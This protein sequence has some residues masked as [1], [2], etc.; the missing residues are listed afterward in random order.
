M[1]GR[2]P[3]RYVVHMGEL[4]LYAIG[5][6]EV[7]DVF[8]ASP[9]VAQDF[10]RIVAE[11]FPPHT[12]TKAPGMLGKLGPLLRRPPDAVILQPDTPVEADVADLLA[13]RY[14]RPERQ[15]AAWRL[16]GAYLGA[17]AW[18]KHRIELDV[19]R[20]NDL[21]FDLAR[22]GVHP[23]FGPGKLINTELSLPL[24]PY[25]GLSTGC[26]RHSQALLAAA[27]WRNALP[28]LAA[29][30]RAI[31]EPYAAWLAQFHHYAQ[32]APQRGRPVPDVVVIYRANSPSGL[33]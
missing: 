32:A 19:N 28:H 8:C 30:N 7:R 11:A 22:A 1:S 25:R 17:K 3:C 24:Q 10:R 12:T 2:R 15:P 5:V 4:Q 31:A 27:A 9:G 13:G 6:D 21:E 20:Y 16:L 33:D 23:Q 26:T 14:I 18:S 29:E